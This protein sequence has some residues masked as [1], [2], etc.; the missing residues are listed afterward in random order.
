M[1]QRI[2]TVYLL[3][4]NIIL[5]WLFKAPIAQLE[6]NNSQF[7]LF[8]HNR[9]EPV[10]AE[11][12]IEPISTWPVSLL[13]LIII[14]IGLFV[15]FQFKNRIRQIRLCI[16]SILLQFGLVG[17]IYYFT[18]FTLRQLGGIE[19]VF[20]WPVVIPFISIVLTYLALKGIQKD[21]LLIK[22][23]DRFRR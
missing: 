12:Q 6:L 5:L 17:L 8:F 3:V 16:F 7:L 13:L 18:K 1:I 2:Q 23:I 14:S 20:L 22:S 9:I 21:E 10:S 11:S 15:I 4:A 19:S